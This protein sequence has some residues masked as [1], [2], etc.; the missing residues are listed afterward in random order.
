MAETFYRIGDAVVYLREK[1]KS[2]NKRQ[3]AFSA[4]ITE[5]ELID[6][7]FAKELKSDNPAL[8]KILKACNLSWEAFEELFK[9]HQRSNNLQ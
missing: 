9:K 6:L 1:S 3:F 4:G 8:K 2:P 7:E 5:R